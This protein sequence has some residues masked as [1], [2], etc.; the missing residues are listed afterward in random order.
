MV[1]YTMSNQ[2]AIYIHIQNYILGNEMRVDDVVGEV[3]E[4]MVTVVEV[5]V[6]V[7]EVMVM[8]VEV[9]VVVAKGQTYL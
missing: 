2:D 3:V 5:M 7:V 4:V 6:M 9:M 1:Y 8:V